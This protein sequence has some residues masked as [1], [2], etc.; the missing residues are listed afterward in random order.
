MVHDLQGMLLVACVLLSVCTLIHSAAPWKEHALRRETRRLRKTI[1]ADNKRIDELNHA[2]YRKQAFVDQLTPDYSRAQQLRNAVADMKRVWLDPASTDVER[3]RVLRDNL[4]VLA[5]DYREIRLTRIP[6]GRVKLSGS[7]QGDDEPVYLTISL[8]TSGAVTK[9]LL[10]SSL[11]EAQ[12]QISGLMPKEIAGKRVD[13][14]VIGGSIADGV[15]DMAFSSDA[16]GS[17]AIRIRPITYSDLI[18]RAELV[19]NP[20]IGRP[21]SEVV[22]FSGGKGQRAAA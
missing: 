5:P 11:E 15:N 12:A 1:E 22:N 17:A 6:R 4:W 2:L 18:A 21:S 20:P 16:N 10:E 8:K 7:A 3:E 9:G 13:C 19:A 14:L